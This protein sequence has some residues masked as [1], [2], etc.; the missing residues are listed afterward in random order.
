M[1]YTLI[2]NGDQEQKKKLFCVPG[3]GTTSILF[4]QWQKYL[5]ELLKV[6]YMDIPGRGYMSRKKEEKTMSGIG[7]SLAEE[8]ARKTDEGG[9]FPSWPPD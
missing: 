4:I 9:G 1:L 3:G 8:V 5:K 7:R 2:W 6:E